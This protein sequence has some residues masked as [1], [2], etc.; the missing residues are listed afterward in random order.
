[1]DLTH[2]VSDPSIDFHE[3]HVGFNV[4]TKVS[5]TAMKILRRD[6]GEDG[7]SRRLAEEIAASGEPWNGLQV[8]QP[9]VVIDSAIS[10]SARIGVVAVFSA[11]EGY[12]RGVEAE[13]Q[14]W[15]S[16]KGSAPPQRD[17]ETA[18]ADDVDLGVTLGKTCDRLGIV[19]SER[20]TFEPAMKF[21]RSLRNCVAHRSGSASTELATLRAD[22]AV[23]RALELWPCRSGAAI[24]EVPTIEVGATVA[25]LPRHAILCSDVC[26]QFARWVDAGLIAKLGPEAVVWWAARH[27]VLAP[28]DPS[29]VQIHRTPVSAIHLALT[30]RYR[31]KNPTAGETTSHLRAIGKWDL[32]L[33][34]FERRGR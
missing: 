20:E 29:R 30:D 21:F 34:T 4:V 15:A 17:D 33:R 32:V 16:V 5:T 7:F 27:A 12:L 11:F 9:E 18:D 8:D 22:P 14:R 1:M 26:R 6:T 28:P 2:A 10:Y 23:A 13:V 25:L 24:P 3:F 19:V 31:V